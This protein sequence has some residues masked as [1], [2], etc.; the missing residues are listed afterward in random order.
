MQNLGVHP[1]PGN[2]G[3]T[4]DLRI[5]IYTLTKVPSNLWETKIWKHHPRKK[6]KAGEL[7][8]VWLPTPSPRAV[9]RYQ[10]FRLS[11]GVKAK[12]KPS[13][14][15]PPAQLFPSCIQFN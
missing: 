1:R 15:S 13:S 5:R 8:L 3:S 2:W 12:F 10:F 4:L 7:P 14:T 9:R 6:G 11:A